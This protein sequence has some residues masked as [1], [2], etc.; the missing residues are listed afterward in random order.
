MKYVRLDPETGCAALRLGSACRTVAGRR[1]GIGGEFGQERGTAV[2]AAGAA[3][4]LERA[5]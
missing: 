3:A 5:G 4:F 2:I 1:L